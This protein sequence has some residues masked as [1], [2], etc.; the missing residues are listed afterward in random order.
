MPPE[1]ATDSSRAARS[2][3]ELFRQVA[4][5]LSRHDYYLKMHGFRFRTILETISRF[6]PVAGG[7][8]L[9]VGCWPGYLSMYFKRS[10]WE[11]DAIDLKPDRIPDVI[12]SG[13]AVLARNLNE[14]PGL[15][16][17]DGVFD[18]IVFTEVLEH[19]DPRLSARHF[20]E[21]RRILKPGGHLVLTTPNRY[22]LNGANLNPFRSNASQVDAEGH[23]H[24]KEYKL[25]EVIGLVS[26]AGMEPVFSERISFYAH[27]G[28]SDG[29]G[30]FPLGEWWSRGNRLRNAA[31]QV[32]RLPRMIPLLKDSLICVARG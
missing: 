25:A 12:E 31:K 15:P 2:G 14:E 26:G 19:L 23:G 17:P 7:R 4:R 9:D 27:L 11:V 18:W 20:S 22:S 8:L 13:V 3:E 24:W 1:T 32:L 29:E 16:Y 30:Y 10:G 6:Q 21:F 28:R 5:E